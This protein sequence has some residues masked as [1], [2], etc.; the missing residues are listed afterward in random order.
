VQNMWKP[1]MRCPSRMSSLEV[2]NTLE[3]TARPS[4]AGVTACGHA[5]FKI[6]QNLS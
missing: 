5:G 2:Q 4:I 1:F 3:E 6:L